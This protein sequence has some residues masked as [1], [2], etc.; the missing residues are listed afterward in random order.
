[1]LCSISNFAY[2]QE[3]ATRKED[4]DLQETMTQTSCASTHTRD[5]FANLTMVSYSK[6]CTEALILNNIYSDV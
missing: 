1:M 5:L 4:F 6:H 2:Y 3:T